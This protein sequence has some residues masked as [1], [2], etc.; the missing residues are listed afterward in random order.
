MPSI[1]PT[2]S[3]QIDGKPLWVVDNIASANEIANLF[4]GLEAS[5]FKRNEIARPDTASFKHWA[6]NLQP[7]QFSQL[8]FFPR[9]LETVNQLTADQYQVYRGYVNY[10]SYGDMLFTHTDC[11]PEHNEM[12]ALMYVAPHWDIEWGG[13]TLYYNKFDDCEFACTPKPGRL[14]IFHGAI[15]HAGRP[16]NKVCTMPRYTLAFKLEKVK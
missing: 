6:L 5:A 9:L 14:A 3:K 11:L 1:T 7:Q 12:T 4:N 10:S 15:K 8:P 16:P 2:H 13:E